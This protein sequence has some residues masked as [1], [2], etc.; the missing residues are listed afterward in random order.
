[1]NNNSSV[2]NILFAD[3]NEI[4]YRAIDE[5]LK[6]QIEEDIDLD[7]KSQFPNDLSRIICAF[8]NT[9]GGIILLG[10][11]EIEK[12]RRPKYP[13]VGIKGDS[14]SIRQAILNISFDNIYPPIEPEIKEVNLP[15]SSSFIFFI[16]VAQSPLLHSVDRR[17]RVYIRSRD[18]NRG[19]ELA[20]INQLL[21][22]FEKRDKSIKLRD[23]LLENAIKNS[24]NFEKKF[25][26]DPQEINWKDGCHLQ[27]SLLP[28]FPS[29]QIFTDIRELLDEVN[30][31]D[32]VVSNWFGVERKVPWQKYHFRT[33]SHG[34]CLEDRG[35]DFA[36]QYIEFGDFGQIFFDFLIK[37]IE[38]KK[39]LIPRNTEQRSIESFI[40]LS[41]FDISMLLVNSFYSKIRFNQPVLLNATLN[42][43]EDILLH[44]DW[45]GSNNN[46]ANERL[47]KRCLDRKIVLL[48]QEFNSNDLIN[49]LNIILFDLAKQLLWSFGEGW[50][51][52]D[53][54]NWLSKF[55]GIK[56]S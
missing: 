22:L 24:E 32:Q 20:S 12:T 38:V 1:V 17:T 48:Y 3:I 31:L 27:I 33:I 46:S 55:S 16:R 51:N 9:Q 25:Q 19:Y 13:P 34:V 10:V 5:F 35:L 15:D 26:K 18:N 50:D 2:P 6:N 40:V 53:I 52:K 37:P 4:D 11:E 28:I 47:S 44:F 54:S 39:L 21:W 56:N 14:Q 42:N 8:A 29:I 45:P 49:N 43:V 30:S 41:S 23:T 7:Y 36:A